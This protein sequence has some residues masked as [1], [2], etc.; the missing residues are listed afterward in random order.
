MAA[1]RSYIQAVRHLGA[2]ETGGVEGSIL[3]VPIETP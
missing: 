2:A 1:R 3:N